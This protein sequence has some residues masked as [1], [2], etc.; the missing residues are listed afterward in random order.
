MDYRTPT[1]YTIAAAL[2]TTLYLASATE[3]TAAPGTV[4]ETLLNASGSG[5]GEC[6]DAWIGT[7]LSAGLFIVSEAL[8]F[9]SKS[10]SNGIIHTIVNGLKGIQKK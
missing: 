5:L 1:V 8:P 3:T 7:I 9:I 2:T 10:P 6:G 4:N